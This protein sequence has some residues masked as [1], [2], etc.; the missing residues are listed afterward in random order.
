LAEEKLA[1]TDKKM[2]E[3]PQK[4]LFKDKLKPDLI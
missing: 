4:L 3:N 1:Q 2:I